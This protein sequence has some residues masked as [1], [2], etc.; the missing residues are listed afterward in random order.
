MSERSASADGEPVLLTDQDRSLWDQAQ[1][2][3]GVQLLTAALSKGMV[4]AY[5]LQGEQLFHPSAATPR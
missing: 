3:E 2:A 4:G 5:Q 1:I